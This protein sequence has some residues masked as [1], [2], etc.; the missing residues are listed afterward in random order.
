M[1]AQDI[2]RQIRDLV[3][4]N[5][6]DHQLTFLKG[7]YETCLDCSRLRERLKQVLTLTSPDAGTLRT[8]RRE[9]EAR[10][11]GL[12]QIAEKLARPSLIASAD[13]IYSL[14]KKRAHRFVCIL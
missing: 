3:V 8:T 12:S 9:P 10:L 14:L 5:P 11:V 2:S 7:R 6:R 4:G 1:T 13:Q